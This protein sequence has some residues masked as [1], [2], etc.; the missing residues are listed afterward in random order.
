VA[1]TTTP[2]NLAAAARPASTPVARRATAHEG[3]GRR[4]ERGNDE[5]RLRDVAHLVR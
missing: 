5:E 4:R 2:K 3:A 1:A